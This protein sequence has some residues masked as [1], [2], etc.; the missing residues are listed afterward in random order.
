MAK[1][2]QESDM[3][4]TD[5]AEI[6]GSI[7]SGFETILTNDALNF[8]STLTSLYQQRR[9]ELL[10]KRLRIAG[11]IKKGILPDFLPETEDVRK[12]SWKIGELPSDLLFRR[13]EITGPVDRKMMINALNSGADVY[14]ADF[15]DSHSPTWQGTIQGQ[16]NLKDAVDGQIEYTSAEGK[17][18]RLKDKTAVLCVRPRGLHLAEKH[19]LIK[20]EPVPACLFDFGLSLYHNHEKLRKKGTGPYYYLPKLEN[21]SEAAFW[22]DIFDTS[23]QMLGLPH[24][25]IKCTV[26]IENIL[27]AF[28]MDEILH[29]LRDHITALNFGRW[30]Y[31]F[32]FIK[33]LGWNPDYL[34]PD[35][36]L[37]PMTQH[38]LTSCAL[39]LVQTCHKRG[40]Y[41]IGGMAANVPTRNNPEAGKMAMDRVITD[42]VREVEQGFDGAW[43]AH[44]DLVPV[45]MKVFNDHMT[46]PNQISIKHEGTRITSRDL[47]HAPKGVITEAGIR[48]NIGV[49]LRYLD[50]WLKGNG[51]V[52]INNLMEDAAT[53]EICRA[54][55]WQWD[56]HEASLEDGR[57]FSPE[58]FRAILKNEV[59]KAVPEAGKGARGDGLESA[60]RMLDKLATDR[61][62]PDF[63]TLLAYDNLE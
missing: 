29:E 15:E 61:E 30:D 31:I 60:A 36:A 6:R 54:Q 42:K 21:H 20:G 44:P 28:E 46:G 57:R 4:E 24:D 62:F 23:E 41:A 35:R 52:A 39:L 50:S 49:S 58:L 63:M 11:R 14:M 3:P 2:A 8:V 5:H 26:L 45:V 33:K 53:V 12:S 59:E 48:A 19:V 47:L 27:A 51:C 43:V 10:E 13:V 17:T 16:M 55:L 9:A 34:L 40:A 22:N 32:S 37:L 25:T 38:F 1:L 7:N 56:Y 18:Y